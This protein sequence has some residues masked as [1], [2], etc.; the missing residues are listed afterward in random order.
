[1]NSWETFVEKSL[2]DVLLYVLYALKGLCALKC[3][4]INEKI[5]NKSRKRSCKYLEIKTCKMYQ[6]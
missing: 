5:K 2:N 1:M 3:L 6:K 4:C